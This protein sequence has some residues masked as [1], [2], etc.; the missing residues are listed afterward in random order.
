MG[1]GAWLTVLILMSQAR[2]MF[3]LMFYTI[4]S[5]VVPEKL[6]GGRIDWLHVLAIETGIFGKTNFPS[7]C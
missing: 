1:S 2:S 3:M 4:G 6:L 7:G 5:E